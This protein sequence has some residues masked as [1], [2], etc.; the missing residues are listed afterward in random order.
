LDETGAA[1][2]SSEG[3]GDVDDDC[4]VD[5]VAL[6]AA[7]N[8]LSQNDP[9]VLIAEPVVEEA[10]VGEAEVEVEVEACLAGFVPKTKSS[11]KNEVV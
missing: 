9:L 2:R 3:A 8:S 11:S 4:D 7:R 6:P 1:K 10:G 5:D